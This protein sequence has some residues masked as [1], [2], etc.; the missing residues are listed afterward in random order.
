MDVGTIQFVVVAGVQMG[1]LAGIFGAINTDVEI[2]T[3]T[4]CLKTT[5]TIRASHG[6]GSREVGLTHAEVTLFWG[7]L[8]GVVQNSP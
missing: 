8:R 1:L 5:Q 3:G 4:V 7:F 6:R 2:S